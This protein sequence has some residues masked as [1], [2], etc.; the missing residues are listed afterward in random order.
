MEFLNLMKQWMKEALELCDNFVFIQSENKTYYF[1]T[2]LAFSFL[3]LVI[4]L[5]VKHIGKK[6]LPPTQP[7]TV[8]LRFR[9][10]DKVMFYGRKM[11]RKVRTSLQG[12]FTAIFVANSSL[13]VC[14]FYSYS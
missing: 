2:A 6:F 3:L 8:K 5:T 7:G 13:A 14:L 9:K 10:R 4:Y 11:L 1:L 12:L